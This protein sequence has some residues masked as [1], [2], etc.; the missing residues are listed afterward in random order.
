MR[1]T[2]NENIK[3]IPEKASKISAIHAALK[4]FLRYN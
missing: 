3:I 1:E 2:I 4:G